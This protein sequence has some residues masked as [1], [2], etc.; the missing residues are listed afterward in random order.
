VPATNLKPATV[1]P[2]NVESAAPVGRWDFY[3]N[4]TSCVMKLASWKQNRAWAI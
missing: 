3:I 4:S 1:A 2:V